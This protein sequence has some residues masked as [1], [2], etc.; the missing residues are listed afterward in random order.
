MKVGEEGGLNKDLGGGMDILGMM[1]E[2]G[3]VRGELEKMGVMSVD[4]GDRLEGLER[5]EE[6]RVMF[7]GEGI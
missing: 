4:G 1:V 7:R 5:I 2:N 3:E 6:G